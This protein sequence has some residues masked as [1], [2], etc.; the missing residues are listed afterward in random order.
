ME[1]FENLKKEIKNAC[2][3]N[4]RRYWKVLKSTEN[5][6]VAKFDKFIFEVKSD[7]LYAMNTLDGIP[8]SVDNSYIHIGFNYHIL[9]Y[10]YGT[11]G[12]HDSENKYDKN[13]EWFAYI[14]IADF[15]LGHIGHHYVIDT[16][17]N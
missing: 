16:E 1:G 7:M 17:I 14:L 9:D 8:V 3:Y 12:R 13:A 6:I 11:F 5:T 10:E 2:E 15:D 4:A